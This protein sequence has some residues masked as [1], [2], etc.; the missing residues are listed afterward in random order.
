VWRAA[1]R[2]IERR[3]HIPRVLILVVYTSWSSN[4]VLAVDAGAGPI[5]VKIQLSRASTLDAL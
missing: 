2:K 4:R 5:N 3:E 1:D